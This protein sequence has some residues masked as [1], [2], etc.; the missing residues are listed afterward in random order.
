M[1][2]EWRSYDSAAAT[3]DR[4]AVR[5]I[6]A[7]PAKDLVARVGLPAGARIL[8]VGTGTGVAALTALEFA[9]PRSVAVGIDPSLDM[10]RAARRKGLSQAVRGLAPGLPFAEGIFDVV[11]ANFVLA[12]FACYETALRDLVRVLRPRGRLGITA[13]GSMESDPRKLWREV[14]DSFVGKEAL[15]SALARA[16]PWEER[17]SDAAHLKEALEEAGLAN[18]DIKNLEYPAVMTVADFLSIREASLAA[19]FMEQELDRA[20]WAQFKQTV[21]S[22]LHARFGDPIEDTREAYLAIGVKP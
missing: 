2:R 20:Q 6:F 19:R 8:D 3:H 1:E 4:L 11:L 12:H 17:F 9:G 10:L 22:E 7:A 14:A 16:L 15:R 5:Y 13:W 18:I 21:A